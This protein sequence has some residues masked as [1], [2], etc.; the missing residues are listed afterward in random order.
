MDSTAIPTNRAKGRAASAQNINKR[1]GRR[2][3]DELAPSSKK[4][5]FQT[6]EA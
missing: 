2:K 3:A 5:Y 4:L 1:K 6:E